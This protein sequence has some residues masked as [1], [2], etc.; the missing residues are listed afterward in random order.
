M[1]RPNTES[2]NRCS[3]ILRRTLAASLA[4]WDTAVAT[5]ALLYCW[6]GNPVSIGLFK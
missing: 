5:L 1:L 6:T 3:L 2:G 4:P